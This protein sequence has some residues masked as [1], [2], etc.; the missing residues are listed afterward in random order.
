[1]TSV[2]TFEQL[3]AE[4]DAE[5]TEGWDF[6]WLNNRATEQRPSWKFFDALVV[7]MANVDAVLD[8]QTGGGERFSEILSQIEIRPRLIAATESW[9]CW[10]RT[11]SLRC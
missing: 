9:C 2:P 1:M 4:G 10:T 6:S 5:P 11:R 7:R 3:V 8:V